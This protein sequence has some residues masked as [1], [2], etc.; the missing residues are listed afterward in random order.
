MSWKTNK[1]SGNKFKTTKSN[2]LHSRGT[3]TAS[4]GIKLKN[5]SKGIS[6][7]ET[8]DDFWQEMGERGATSEVLLEAN[9]SANEA[10]KGTIDEGTD[11]VYWNIPPL[12]VGKVAQE[13]IIKSR[14]GIRKIKEF[15]AE[16]AEW[17]KY[18]RDLGWDDELE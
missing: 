12:V 15:M 7:Q 13:K 4:S 16:N 6:E 3:T 1:S 9:L 14:G 8:F 10:V 17:E 18:K 2:R 11:M 5:N